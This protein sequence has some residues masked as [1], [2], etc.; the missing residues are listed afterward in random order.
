MEVLH[1]CISIDDFDGYWEIALQEVVLT[2]TITNVIKITLVPHLCQQNV[3]K[4]F[5]LYQS[6][7]VKR[8]TP[9]MPV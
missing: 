3:L 1:E 2:Y 8:N 4:P 7:S 6:A 9:T 5:D